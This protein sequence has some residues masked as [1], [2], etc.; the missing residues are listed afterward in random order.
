MSS[1]INKNYLFNDYDWS[2]VERHIKEKLTQE[3]D[4][5]E[6]GSLLNTSAD[7]LCIYLEE[8]YRINTPILDKGHLTVEQREV[9][10]DVSRD[11]MRDIRDRNRPFHI[12][13]T[14]IDVTIPFVGDADAFK[15][16]PTTYSLNPPR[17]DILQS[18]TL[19]L[20]IQGIQLDPQHVRSEID[21]TL[22][23]IDCCLTNLR[24]SVEQFNSELFTIARERI[25]YRR[26]KLLADQNLVSA[27]GFP[28]MERP[29]TSRTYT[30]PEVR[31]R[32][33][34]TMPQASTAPFQPEPVLTQDDYE[35]ILSVLKNMVLVMERSP[36]AFESMDEETLRSHFLV[37]LNGHYEGQATGETFNYEGKTDILIRV[38][39]RNIFIAECKIWNGQKSLIDTIDQLL[40]Y[41]SWRDTKVAIIIL[42]RRKSFSHVIDEIPET[43]T[44]HPNFKRDIGPTSETDFHY[45]FCHRDD[46][47]RELTLTVMA[48]DIP[49]GDGA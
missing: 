18:D 48:F 46:L 32:I 30:P 5:I 23:S 2:S 25:E 10:I 34:P 39:G 36:S 11:P 44:N 15:F 22:A 21:Q 1:S 29:D 4:S 49:S 16:R 19:K 43:M 7:D 6:G 33:T 40:R 9:K 41:T 37:Q 42:N 26:E 28:L 8:K 14:A 13:G 38:N 27:L 12:T 17:A 35:H 31:R 45:I 3:I 20:T 24:Q 47:N